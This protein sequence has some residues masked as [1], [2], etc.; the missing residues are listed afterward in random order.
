MFSQDQRFVARIYC[1]KMDIQCK[2]SFNLKIFCILTANLVIPVCVVT[3]SNPT[4]ITQEEV[5]EV[6]A[7][8]CLVQTKTHCLTFLMSNCLQRLNT[9]ALH[10]TLHTSYAL[11]IGL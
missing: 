4:S 5:M 8:L 2:D 10:A 1:P 3:S 6:M 7:D 9:H 11:K